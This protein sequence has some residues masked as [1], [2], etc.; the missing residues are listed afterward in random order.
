MNVFA[1]LLGCCLVAVSAKAALQVQSIT[2]LPPTPNLSAVSVGPDS[3]VAA[4][5]NGAI[6]RLFTRNEALANS[7]ESVAISLS[8]ATFGDSLFTIGGSE[9]RIFQ[10]PGNGTWTELV[11]AI[12]T[13]TRGAVTSLA[14][15]GEK[16]VASQLGARVWLSQETVPWESALVLTFPSFRSVT[17]ASPQ[18]LVLVGLSGTIY[19]SASGGVT[20]SWVARSAPAPVGGWLAVTAAAAGRVVAVGVGGR[21]MISSDFGVSWSSVSSPVGSDLNG[22]THTGNGF[23]AVGNAGVM[24]E[25]ADGNV[26]TALNSGTDVDLNGVGSGMQGAMSG[27]TFAVGSGG[28]VIVIAEPPPKPNPSWTTM[29]ECYSGSTY[30]VSVTD[31]PANMVVDWLDSAGTVR[32]ANSPTFE[33]ETPAEGTTN[34]VFARLRNARVPQFLSP[35]QEV[36][37]II[38]RRPV[39]TFSPSATNY[40]RNSSDVDLRRFLTVITNSEP[41]N[42]SE[43]FSGPGVSS[44]GIFSPAA[45]QNGTK[46][47]PNPNIVTYFFQN[48]NGC[49][50]SNTIAVTVFELPAITFNADPVKIRHDLLSTNLA[51]ITSVATNA[52]EG[53]GAFSG[54][55]VSASGLFTPGSAGVNISTNADIPNVITYTFTNSNHVVVSK[56]L[57][58]I[59]YELPIVRVAAD[60]QLIYCRSEGAFELASLFAVETNAV[61]GG[62]VFNE[63]SV[64]VFDP[65]IAIAGTNDI[66]YVFS[67]S[68][69]VVVS[70]TLSLLVSECRLTIELNEE[71]AKLTWFGPLQLQAA[72][73]IPRAVT[74]LTGLNW[75]VLTNGGA[76]TNIYMQPVTRTNEFFRLRK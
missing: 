2:N 35:Q 25:S 71:N 24:L 13:P 14:F 30:S 20:G 7:A 26:W 57:N 50:G 33:F 59:V 58:V 38:N 16:I 60:A 49:Q 36:V 12:S 73:E 32:S 41:D 3:V 8:S 9:G 66:R 68:N 19:T 47:S 42:V 53:S 11:G 31:V 17:A 10:S 21:I 65:A 64:S 5:A 29:T 22:V 39:V 23:I 62:F 45:A 4:G 6:R 44:Q 54:V 27:L 15:T 72:P 18:N 48:A 40:W 34:R 37:L 56:S 63:N 46:D 76:G 55:G 67:N 61:G 43:V 69:G 74:S 28:R 52:A 1:K 51:L 70:G 75:N